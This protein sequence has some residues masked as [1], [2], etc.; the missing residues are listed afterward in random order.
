MIRKLWQ[1]KLGKLYWEKV[2]LKKV[3]WEKSIGK[4]VIQSGFFIATRN[5]IEND[6]FTIYVLCTLRKSLKKIKK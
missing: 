6:I 3:D 4:T 2:Y 5:N 1:I